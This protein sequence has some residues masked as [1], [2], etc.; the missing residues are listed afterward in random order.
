MAVLANLSLFPSCEDYNIMHYSLLLPFV[1]LLIIPFA[2]VE[3]AEAEVL[4]R[5]LSA[6][7]QSASRLHW[8]FSQESFRRSRAD[9]SQA[10][11]DSDPLA[12]AHQQG[13]QGFEPLPGQLA[14]GTAVFNNESGKFL[15]DFKLD[16]QKYQ[17]FFDGEVFASETPTRL[18]D[19]DGPAFVE[20]SDTNQSGSIYDLAL[21]CSSFDFVP[22]RI[23][24]LTQCFASE[25]SSISLA[26]FIQ[27]LGDEKV[28]KRIVESGGMFQVEFPAYVTGMPAGSVAYH[29]D[30]LG[31]LKLVSWTAGENWS[32]SITIEFYYEE[33]VDLLSVPSVV[34]YVDWANGQLRRVEFDGWTKADADDTKFEI[35]KGAI[36]NDHVNQFTYTHIG[37]IDDEARAARLYAMQYQLEL[38]DT[39]RGLRNHQWFWII[40]VLGLALIGLVAG[41]LKWKANRMAGMVLVAAIF[42]NSLDNCGAQ[43]HSEVR[44]ESLS[45]NLVRWQD[46]RGWAIGKSEIGQYHL[47]QCGSKVTMLALEISKREYDVSVVSQMLK[48]SRK[49][50]SMADIKKV[51]QAHGFSVKARSKLSIEQVV[52]L[53]SDYDFLLI[54]IPQYQQW[55]YLE[56]HYVIVFKNSIGQVS[57]LDPPR[58]P[59]NLGE[60]SDDDLKGLSGLTALLCEKTDA[61][62]A[63]WRI[64]ESVLHISEDSFVDDV[65][66]GKVK[67]L[68]RGDTPV[69]IIAAKP[70]CGC[71]QIDFNPCVLESGK[72][73]LVSVEIE[74]NQWGSGS[75]EIT[76]IDSSGFQQLVELKGSSSLAVSSNVE[77]WASAPIVH[78]KYLQISQACGMAPLALD[79][80]VSLPKFT[81]R[82]LT[83]ESKVVTAE[84]EVAFEDDGIGVLLG[85]IRLSKE[86][87]ELASS[88]IPFCFSIGLLQGDARLGTIKFEVMRSVG[89]SYNTEL[90]RDGKCQVEIQLD[91]WDGWSLTSFE[92]PG[93]QESAIQDLG[94]GNYRILL[95]PDEQSNDNVLC[96]GFVKFEHNEHPT[97]KK[98]LT[99]F[100]S[101]ANALGTSE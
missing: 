50:I 71:V 57:F 54:H 90:F 100:R 62:S 93:F 25:E 76:F 101:M 27:L 70:S 51:L 60:V 45:P 91:D 64:A 37:G 55:D 2:N 6:R 3:S 34:N 52:K 89:V 98:Q 47:S 84:C 7:Y 56:P 9:W 41:I 4:S 38:P 96:N 23:P 15:V 74:K 12:E 36:V 69:A 53:T 24:Q 88:G 87:I 5:L 44:G 11:A 21:A 80:K 83:I 85:S 72:E 81:S 63:S 40:S 48:P 77:T 73:K 20:I 92:F 26:E 49:G 8:Q 32:P 18:R 95:T 39:P 58:P 78:R 29:F 67:L 14:T 42:G 75:Q 31:A 13:L 66:K 43:S 30:A 28:E 79:F 17:A 82:S 86:E 68:N 16:G 33:K 94:D 65:F 1:L 99:F 46:N 10:S 59:V 22:F 19:G 35:P 97:F 61:T